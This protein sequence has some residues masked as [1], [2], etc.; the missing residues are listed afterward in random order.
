MIIQEVSNMAKLYIV[1]QNFE[2]NRNCD[3]VTGTVTEINDHDVLKWL[4]KNSHKIPH[5]GSI[6]NYNLKFV[7][8]FEFFG[9]G[10]SISKMNRN[11]IRK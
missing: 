7:A 4:E 6:Y 2:T 3:I 1:G 11:V 9:G 10:I 8:N 5:R